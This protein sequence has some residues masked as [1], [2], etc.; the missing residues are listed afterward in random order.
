MSIIRVQRKVSGA[1]IPNLT[2]HDSRLRLDSLGLLTWLLCHGDHWQVRVRN[3]ISEL[4]AR[5]VRK[6]GGGEEWIARMLR[7]LEVAGYLTR[8]RERMPRGTWLWVSIIS[9]VSKIPAAS[10][11]PGSAGHGSARDISPPE[12]G[13]QKR[14]TSSDL[15]PAEHNQADDDDQNLINPIPENPKPKQK[16]K[17][18]TEY[19]SPEGEPDG[20]EIETKPYLVTTADLVDAL[21]GA[22]GRGTPPR[23][24]YMAAWLGAIVKR[25]V[26]QSE[27]KDVQAAALARL[28][29]DV[30]QRFINRREIGALLPDG[31]HTKPPTQLGDQL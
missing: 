14:K 19:R 3:L 13:S 17:P 8:K 27:A 1:Y 26:T 6:R 31:S 18:K 4:G 12:G 20:M 30:V 10:T 9:D 11:I 15:E 5:S 21:V 2:A 23:K 7:D 25:H 16:T 28:P 29:L 24:G 22:I